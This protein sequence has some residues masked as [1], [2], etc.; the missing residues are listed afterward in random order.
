M[1]TDTI[2]EDIKRVFILFDPTLTNGVKLNTINTIL[3]CCQIY[4]TP[5]SLSKQLKPFKSKSKVIHFE[6]F[7][8]LASKLTTNNNTIK[9]LNKRFKT[10]D[11]DSSGQL[12]VSEFR[13]ILTTFSPKLSSPYIEEL[14]ETLNPNHQPLIYYK[15]SLLLLS[16]VL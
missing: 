8:K 16:E 12:T 15:P 2:I 11:I 13:H 6:E 4:P 3:S 7:L 14:I 1:S 10:F 9:S 5:S